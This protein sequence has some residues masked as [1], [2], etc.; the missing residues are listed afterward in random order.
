MLLPCYI[1]LYAL[2]NDTITKV[3]KAVVDSQQDGFF[4][5]GLYHDFLHMKV[6]KENPK[7]FQAAV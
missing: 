4:I 3:N 5:D 1:R 6:M 7:A 2:A